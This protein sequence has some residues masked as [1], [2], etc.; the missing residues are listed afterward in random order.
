[1]YIYTLTSL[2]LK[3]LKGRGVEE[4]KGRG[5][6][7][8]KGRGVEEGSGGGEGE[9]SGGG[10]G[11]GSGGGEGAGGGGQGGGGRSGKR[12]GNGEKRKDHYTCLAACLAPPDMV[13]THGEVPQ[14]VWVSLVASLP[15]LHP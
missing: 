4:G 5:V 7:E 2:Q 11:E 15:W 1:M 3:G 14:W 10:E 12:E 8:G 9:G 13:F 6:E